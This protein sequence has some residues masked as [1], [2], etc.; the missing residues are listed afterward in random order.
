[1]LVING[2]YV[3]CDLKVTQ[4]LDCVLEKETTK[5]YHGER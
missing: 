5:N 1:M 2:L 4:R 3:M